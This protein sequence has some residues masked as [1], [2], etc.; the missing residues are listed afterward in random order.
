MH[1]NIEIHHFKCALNCFPIVDGF[2]GVVEVRVQIQIVRLFA[3]CAFRS[4]C[5]HNN[6]ANNTH[7][8]WVVVDRGDCCARI[9]MCC[10][11][12]ICLQI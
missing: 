9:A 7:I 6:A 3:H 2:S 8:D 5:C 1:T 11:L 12:H 4:Q 10:I